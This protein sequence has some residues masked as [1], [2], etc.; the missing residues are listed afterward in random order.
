MDRFLLEI[1]I[2]K[3]TPT[4]I[5][6]TSFG[7]VG[8]S[9]SSKKSHIFLEPTLALYDVIVPMEVDDSAA[10]QDS[11]EDSQDEEEVEAFTSS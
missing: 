9:T 6:N 7:N 11:K 4:I 5:V 2:R 8:D 1:V 10:N 3:L